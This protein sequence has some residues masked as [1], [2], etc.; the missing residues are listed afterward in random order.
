MQLDERW[1]LSNL[2]ASAE[3][4]SGG[5]VRA[6]ARAPPAHPSHR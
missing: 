3:R 5:G 6:W 4:H 2:S 1:H